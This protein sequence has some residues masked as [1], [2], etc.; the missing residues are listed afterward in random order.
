MFDFAIAITDQCIF[1]GAKFRQQELWAW[2]PVWSPTVIVIMYFIVS[3]ILIP[4]GAVILVTSSKLYSSQRIRYDNIDS[5]NVGVNSS[6]SQIRTCDIKLEINDTLTGPVYFYYGIV[7]FYQNARTYVTSRS[8]EQLRGVSNPSVSDCD[9]LIK[10]ESGVIVPCGLTANSRFNDTFRLCA[11]ETCADEIFLNKSGI[12]WPIDRKKRFLGSD[13]YTAVQNN[14]I[15]DEDFMVWMRL[16]AYRSWK[17]LYRIIDE[18]LS[19]GIYTVRI[20]AS[21]PVESFDGEKF[22]YLSQT[23][24]FGGPNM[25][26]GLAYIIIGSITLILAVLFLIRSRMATE[27]DLPPETTVFLDGIVKNPVNPQTESSSTTEI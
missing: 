15:R 20:A 10:N 18:N 6:L 27:L 13:N 12:A 1:L 14:I 23:T 11:S 4:L 19:P 3:F 24:W 5:C 16:S 22:F 17:K 9:P 21:Y 2:K 8:D 26:L 7:N 25:A